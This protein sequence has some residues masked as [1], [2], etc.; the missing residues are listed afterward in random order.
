M[1]ISRLTLGLESL[2]FAYIGRIPKE[3]SNFYQGNAF[4]LIVL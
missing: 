3:M 4:H 1:V 2:V